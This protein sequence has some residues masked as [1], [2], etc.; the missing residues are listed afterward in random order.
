[1]MGNSADRTQGCSCKIGRNIDRYGLE[2]LNEELQQRRYEDEASLR[3]LADYINRRILSAVL[4]ESDIDLMD[5]AYGAVSSDEA[6][7]AVYET[8]ASDEASPD[9]EAYVRKRLEQNDIEINEIESHWVTHPTVRAH[10]NDCLDIETD[11]PTR[12]TTESAQDTIEWARTRCN[13]IV[14]QT[15]SRLVSSGALSISDY[16]VSVVVQISCSNCENTYRPIELLERESCDCY[17][18]QST[19]TDHT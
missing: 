18:I 10:L 6:L 11:R 4:S 5:A 12:I 16:D 3:D 15:I 2:E 17:D 19:S 13:Q 7:A 9:R 14:T 8:L 1:M